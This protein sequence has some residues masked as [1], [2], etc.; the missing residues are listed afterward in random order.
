MK[1]L[2]DIGKVRY[3]GISNCNLKQ[4]KE[5]NSN[6]KIDFFEGV[7]NLECKVNEDIGILDYCKENNIT[8]IPYQ[9]LRRNRTALRNYPIL[10]N[11]AN[12]YNK[13]Q[14]QIILNWIIKEKKMRPLIKCTNID[15]INQN[16]DSM[17][18]EMSK[19]DYN[20]L[21][22]FRNKEFDNVKID[23]DFTGEGVTID[24]LANQFE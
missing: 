19:D 24:Q 21:N 16:L 12:K 15:R 4:L 14:N 9:A 6:I 11:L 13:T 2:V 8:F 18:F 1:R 23:W 17:N 5:I 7:Y 3:L 22:E 10:V 20:S